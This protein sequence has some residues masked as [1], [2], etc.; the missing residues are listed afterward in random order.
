MVP[1]HV[2]AHATD[3]DPYLT[4]DS[5]AAFAIGQAIRVDDEQMGVKD[6]DSVF[7]RIYV[8]RGFNGTWARSHYSHSDIYIEHDCAHFV[9]LKMV[10][11]Y[12]NKSDGNTFIETDYQ[13]DTAFFG[14][15]T[16][17]TG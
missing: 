11:T 4:V 1:G 14:D 16:K 8:I 12:P 5:V 3:D 9:H 13:Y 6:V 15:Q 17:V 7:H 2:S 10:K